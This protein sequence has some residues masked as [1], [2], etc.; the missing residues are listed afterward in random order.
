VVVAPTWLSGTTAD[1]EMVIPGILVD[2]T[3]FYL[4]LVDA[5]GDGVS[6][7]PS[8]SATQPRSAFP[9]FSIRDMVETQHRLLV[10]VLG[11][12]HAEAIVGISM[13]G[14]QA[15]QWAVTYPQFVGRIVS[16]V[17]TPQPTTA[18]LLVWAGLRHA[19]EEDTAY[20]RGAYV[21]RPQMRAVLDQ[22]MSA[23]YTPEYRSSTTV[24]DSF[25]AWLASME[26]DTSFDW[27]DWVR[28]LEALSAFDIAASADRIRIPLLVVVS[29]H[30][31]MVQPGPALYLARR[32][33]ARSIVLRGECGHMAFQCELRTL[34]AVVRRFLNPITQARLETGPQ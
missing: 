28:Q 29:K 24:R 23:I 19:I 16:V 8:N 15:L 25:P 5:L 31:R 3:R 33:R 10:D 27:N 4:V 2:T 9:Q 1:L 14:M 32:L 12:R 34:T 6:S 20:Q 21:R 11:I 17:G 30:D 7:S 26:A 13:G 18:D 22:L